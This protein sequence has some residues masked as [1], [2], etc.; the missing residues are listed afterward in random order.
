MAK[1]TAAF[2]P[3]DQGESD[4]FG[5]QSTATERRVLGRWRASEIARRLIA[6]GIVLRIS[7]AAIGRWLAQ[8]KIRPWP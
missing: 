2:F 3:R 5:L 4:R 1:H 7:A 6:L 8:E